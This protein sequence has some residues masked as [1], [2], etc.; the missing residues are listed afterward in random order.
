MKRS[1]KAKTRD[2]K[3]TTAIRGM[4]K[5]IHRLTVLVNALHDRRILNYEAVEEKRAT[6]RDAWAVILEHSKRIAELERG[7]APKLTLVP[8][9]RLTK[10][11]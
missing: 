7:Q 8:T 3:T 10:E 2:Q 11:G 5:S 6:L 1:T 9:T 4:K